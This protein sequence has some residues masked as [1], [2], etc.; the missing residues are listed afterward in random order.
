MYPSHSVSDL[1]KLKI[2]NFL[3]Q[4]Q[5]NFFFK[6]G[7]TANILGFMGPHVVSVGYSLPIPTA[8]HFKMEIFLGEQFVLGPYF[9]TGGLAGGGKQEERVGWCGFLRTP[10]RG[11]EGLSR[12]AIPSIFILFLEIHASAIRRS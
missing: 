4:A 10:F 11:I 12:F 3:E 1:A 6:G 8:N 9:I 2:F 7:L 5:A